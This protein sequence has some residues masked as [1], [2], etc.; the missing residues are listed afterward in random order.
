MG[1]RSSFIGIYFVPRTT[2]HS[3]SVMN[4][5]F[6]KD[7]VISGIF[8]EFE[9]VNQEKYIKSVL[10]I[11]YEEFL[12]A[13]QRPIYYISEGTTDLD[14]IKAFCKK[15]ELIEH[16]RFLEEKVFP[17]LLEMTLIELKRI[18]LH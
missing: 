2:S 5:A 10:D 14:F 7:Q 4:R 13:R 16:V 6:G 1:I 9:Q 3:E 15:L 11:G 18:L 8:G 12:I 17:I